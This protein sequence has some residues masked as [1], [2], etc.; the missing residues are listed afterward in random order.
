MSSEVNEFIS[1]LER[2]LFWIELSMIA[3]VSMRSKFEVNMI[4]LVSMKAKFELS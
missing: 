2:N 4:V 3:L 1:E